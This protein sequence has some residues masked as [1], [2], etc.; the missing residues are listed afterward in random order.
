[1]LVLQEQKCD[2]TQ[3]CHPCECSEYSCRSRYGRIRRQ[4]WSVATL[5]LHLQCILLLHGTEPSEENPSRFKRTNVGALL[6]KATF[7]ALRSLEGGSECLER[8]I[9]GKDRNLQ[10]SGLVRTSSIH[11]AEMWRSKAVYADLRRRINAQAIHNVGV[12]PL[13]EPLTSSLHA[14]PSQPWTPSRRNQPWKRFNHPVT[15]KS[16]KVPRKRQ[17]PQI[18]PLRMV[19]SRTTANSLC[20]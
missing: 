1:M 20:G 17:Q 18:S 10:E 12:A 7:S 3:D 19:K 13:A 4:C 15:L 16:R 6:S 9:Q 8:N 5:I 11:T 2:D 14:I